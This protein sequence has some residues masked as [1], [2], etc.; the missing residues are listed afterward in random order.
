MATIIELKPIEESRIKIV[1]KFMKC[2]MLLLFVIAEIPNQFIA[3]E[4]NFIVVVELVSIKSSYIIGIL[5]A[6]NVRSQFSI[7]TQLNEPQ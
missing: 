4:C 5:S 6:Y 7:F 3:S 1:Y 2:C